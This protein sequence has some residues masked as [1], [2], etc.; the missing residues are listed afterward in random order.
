MDEV[1]KPEQEDQK[2][3]AS[4]L[5]E[6]KLWTRKN[7]KINNSAGVTSRH[8]LTSRSHDV[9]MTLVGMGGD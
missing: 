5:M 7:N 3:P 4:R 2:Q 6:K 8:F 1:K 9:D